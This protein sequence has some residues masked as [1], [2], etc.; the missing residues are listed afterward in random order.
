MEGLILE[1]SVCC[2]Q[3]QRG[4]LARW[5]RSAVVIGR[6]GEHTGSFLGTRDLLAAL[7]L[8]CWRR[9]ERVPS[10]GHAPWGQGAFLRERQLRR[11]RSF[12]VRARQGA[13]QREGWSRGAPG[14]ADELVDAGE[15]LVV[16]VVDGTVVQEL[17]RQEQRGVRVHRSATGVR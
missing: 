6:C 13:M 15:P 17:S 10:R 5:S 11:P 16:E 14:G 9:T 4:V 12:L 8:L 3:E 2:C 7:L 1:V